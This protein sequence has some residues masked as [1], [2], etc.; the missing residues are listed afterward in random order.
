VSEVVEEQL[1]SYSNAYVEKFDLLSTERKDG[2]YEVRA[3]V[4]VR[5]APLMDVLREADIP[6]VAFDTNTAV[7][8]AQS[9]SREKESAVEV[10]TDLLSRFETLVTVGVGKP[11][12]EP[13]LPSA[14][15][16]A[17]VKVPIV[18][19]ADKEASH[20]W[21]EKFAMVAE[22]RARFVVPAINFRGS[23]SMVGENSEECTGI[24][25]YKF[26]SGATRAFTGRRQPQ[27][28]M[29][30]LTACFSTSP[31]NGGIAMECFGRSFILPDQ[32]NFSCDRTRSPC[33]YFQI[34]AKFPELEI[35]FIDKAGQPVYMVKQ[36]LPQ[37][38]AMPIETSR[39]EPNDRE[40]TFYDIC[41]AE[42]GYPFFS[43]FTSYDVAYG[44]MIVFP[45]GGRDHR[46]EAHVLLSNEIIEQIDT[47][48]ARIVATTP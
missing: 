39:T 24:D 8:T 33:T 12:L 4:L 30:G 6:T 29:R 31:A 7:A 34:A 11:G 36:E 41:S 2:F 28:S 3:R 43:V 1:L 27:E 18:F 48:R 16:Q 42:D 13:Q 35:E 20:E 21:K 25:Y 5:T 26:L 14:P 10:I 40:E 45:L 37:F 9:L 38:P 47:I 19:S 22:E 23:G 44:D 32:N 46:V 15:G 17:W